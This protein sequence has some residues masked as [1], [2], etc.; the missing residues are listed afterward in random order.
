[1]FS[2]SGFFLGMAVFNRPTNISFALPAV[3]YVLW[4]YPRRLHGFLLAAAVPAMLMACYSWTYWGSIMALG[5]GHE[6]GGRHWIHETNFR[7]PLLK[8]MA[9]VL[10][11]PGRGLFV[12][13]PVLIFAVPPIL[14]TL[15]AWTNTHPVYRL[16]AIGAIANLILFSTWSVW[17]GGYSFGYRML[18]E[19]L[20]AFAL[21]LALA[22]ERWIA[23]RKLYRVLFLLTVL[24]SFYFQFLGA[25][26][27]P[28]DWNRRVNIDLNP[29]RNWQWRDS[30]LMSCHRHFI[31]KLT[32]KIDKI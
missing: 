7:Y 13:S 21:F 14:Y 22:W 32:V 18:L 20:P 6:I 26:I 1:V 2:L 9:G 12:F 29:A 4:L 15:W 19:M 11:S 17:W 8:G 31:N 3:V 10:L 5:Q 23:P 24:V 25:W 28:T 27:Y 16:L 30:E